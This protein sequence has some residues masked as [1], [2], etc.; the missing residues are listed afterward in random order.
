[1][2]R[3]D[4]QCEKCGMVTETTDNPESMGCTCGGLMMRLWS[5]PGIVFKGN[6]WGSKP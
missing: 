5:V 1:M 3:Y 2:P 4:Y 6:G